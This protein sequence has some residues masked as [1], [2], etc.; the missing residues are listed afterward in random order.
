MTEKPKKKD[1]LPFQ[2]QRGPENTIL[3][4]KKITDA[5]YVQ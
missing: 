1:W 3:E 4:W 5:I 2:E